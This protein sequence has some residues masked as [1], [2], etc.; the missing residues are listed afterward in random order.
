MTHSYVTHWMP[1]FT[2]DEVP[3]FTLDEVLMKCLVSLLMK[4][5]VS[6]SMPY[7][8]HDSFI[9]VTLDALFHTPEMRDDS[10]Y[11]HS[12]AHSHTPGAIW[13]GNGPP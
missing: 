10:T 4:C 7:I 3:C 2:L 12:D 8:R 13:Y 11:T 6:H 5:L 1:C 9:R